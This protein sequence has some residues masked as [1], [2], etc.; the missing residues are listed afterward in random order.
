M[1]FS[2][3]EYEVDI[4]DNRYVKRCG[5]D[6]KPLPE[7]NW[8]WAPTG[9][10]DAHMPEMWGYLVFTENGEE[11][12]FVDEY[13]LP[14][15]PLI[16]EGFKYRP[17]KVV[18]DSRGYVYILSEG[19]YYGALLY[20]PATSGTAKEFI[21]FYGA[22]TV[23]NN[24]LDAIGAVRI[25]AGQIAREAGSPRST[26]VVLVGALS[27][28]LPFAEEQ[29]RDAIS[30]RVPPKTVEANLEAFDRGRAAAGSRVWAEKTRS[31]RRK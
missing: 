4:E 23:T 30:R 27:T 21:G 5:A 7:H 9:V 15:S 20:A 29:W 16:P 19:S 26:N 13:T 28:A 24:I 11:A 25:P 17:V 22:N 14:D 31:V 1:D 6:G 8:L 12:T 2:R 3:V 10:I 18:A